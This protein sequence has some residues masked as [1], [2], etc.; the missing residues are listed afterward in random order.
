MLITKE[1]LQAKLQNKMFNWQEKR[2]Y[3]L[4]DIERQICNEIYVIY[5]DLYVECFGDIR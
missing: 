4:T 5:R 2:D 3:A 1:E